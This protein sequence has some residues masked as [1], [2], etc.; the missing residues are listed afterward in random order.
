MKKFILQYKKDVI[1]LTTL[2]AIS[3]I[4]ASSNSF[5]LHDVNCKSLGASCGPA[6][7]NGTVT[8]N[9]K[10]TKECDRV[11][12]NSGGLFCV[13]FK[14]NPEVYCEY[15]CTYN[16]NDPI[17]PTSENFQEPRPN[18]QVTNVNYSDDKVYYYGPHP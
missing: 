5:A 4:Y 1:I 7:W 16:T 12:S 2:I 9:I 10:N 14:S 18:F 17:A 15:E 11:E 3:S 6:G 13:V 8:S